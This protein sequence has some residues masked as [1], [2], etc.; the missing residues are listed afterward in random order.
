MTSLPSKLAV[1]DLGNGSHTSAV[2]I[3]DPRKAYKI[4]ETFSNGALM[5]SD[6]YDRAGNLYVTTNAPNVLEFAKGSNSPTFTYSSGLATPQMVTTD[7]AGN[8]YVADRYADGSGALLEYPQGSNTVSFEC[9]NGFQPFG[10]AVDKKG[11][12][13][14]SAVQSQQYPPSGVLLEYKGGLGN[15]SSPTM[16]GVTLSRNPAGLELDKK[17]NLLA[18][19]ER[20]RV[21]EIIAPPY[22][23]VTTTISGFVDPRHTALNKAEN[24][25]Y[26]ADPGNYGVEI[27]SYPSGTYL[28][29]LTNDYGIWQPIGVAVLPKS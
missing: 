23:S 15:C 17:Q 1:A 21:V 27:F 11:T 22:N 10:V 6:W 25:L 14:E 20:N 5:T 28:M 13:F 19:D 12:V 4:I 29:T 9:S 3:L 16:L 26:V 2:E 7:S 18:V 8:V 24:L